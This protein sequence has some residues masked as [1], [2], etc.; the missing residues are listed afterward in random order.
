MMAQAVMVMP[1]HDPEGL[2]LPHLKAVTP[3]LRQIF[4]EAL[5]GITEPTRDA[6]A[7][8]VHW[9]EQEDFFQTRR[10]PVDIPI[11]HQFLSL[12]DE[13]VECYPGQVLH[14]CF[15]DRVAFALQTQHRHAFVADMQAIKGVDVP[16]LFQRSKTAW[17]T[18]PRNYREIEQMAIRV[19][20]FVLGRALDLTWC[21][22]A[23][24]TQQ[25]QAVLPRIC[26]ADLTI[27]AEIVLYLKDEMRTRD[28]DWLAWEDPF[29]H[30]RDAER[31][32]RER[33]ESP[34]ETPKRLAYV[35][36]ILQ[37][38]A[39]FRPGKGT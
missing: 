38:L 37:L 20:E 24:R 23:V 26:S 7:A 1:V 5:L 13:A 32:K 27:L 11:G 3:Q 6:E 18:H 30:R 31:M 2:V 12:Y 33:E 22:L 28:V 17:Q 36:P 15:P 21:H 9:L 34:E 16:L 19:G 8:Y 39:E 29:I 35:I 4:S 10:T 14:L 25:L